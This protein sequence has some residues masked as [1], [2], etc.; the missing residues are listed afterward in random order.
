MSGAMNKEKIFEELRNYH[1]TQFSD[2]I[3]LEVNNLKIE[4]GLIEDKI[5][6]MLLS[7]V[8]GKGEF[9]DSAQ[10]LNTFRDKLNTAASDDID[11]A[12]RNL[13]ASKIGKLLDIMVFAKESNFKLRTV[14]PRARAIVR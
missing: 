6:G 14:R 5:I 8:N 2:K 7:L 10:E 12:S 1:L 4:F 9:I 11:T 13:F 3:S